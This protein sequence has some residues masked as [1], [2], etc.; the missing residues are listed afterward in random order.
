MWMHCLTTVTQAQIIPSGQIFKNKRA[1]KKQE[2]EMYDL[3]LLS[4]TMHSTYYVTT[5]VQHSPWGDIWFRS[6]M[7]PLPSC[8]AMLV[9]CPRLALPAQTDRHIVYQWSWCKYSFYCCSKPACGILWSSFAAALMTLSRGVL[10]LRLATSGWFET[11]GQFVIF[12]TVF[13]LHS[14]SEP[15]SDT[16]SR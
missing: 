7:C 3:G 10:T 5:W 2:T 6:V 4:W 8:L 12:P 9:L 15:D 16:H 14:S 11:N 13:W 1:A